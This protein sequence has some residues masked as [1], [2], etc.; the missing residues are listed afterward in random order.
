MVSHFLL[1]GVFLTQG[2]NLGLPHYRQILYCLS[3]QGSPQN[4]KSG[5]F[6]LLQYTIVPRH[7]QGTNIEV[8]DLETVQL[9][10]LK[11]PPEFMK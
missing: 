3:H 2:L 8:C 7:C 5:H 11:S 4:A 10:D 9:T 6:L 1:Q